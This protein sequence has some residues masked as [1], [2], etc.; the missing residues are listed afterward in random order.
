MALEP[1]PG[2]GLACP[3]CSSTDS[4]VI[5]STR[6]DGNINRRRECLKCEHRFNTVEM[7]LAKLEDIRRRIML[8]D[9]LHELMRAFIDTGNTRRT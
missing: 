6:R 4:A 1:P 8:A 2:P 7:P 3:A 9:K 5:D